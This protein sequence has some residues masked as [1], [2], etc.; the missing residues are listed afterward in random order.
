MLKPDL[1]IE[2]LQDLDLQYEWYSSKVGEDVAERYL[3]AFDQ[4]KLTLCRQPDLGRI[5]H[6]RDR[7]LAKLRSKVVEGS[8]NQHLV[9]YRV[10]GDNLVIFRVLHGMRDLPRRLLEPPGAD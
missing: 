7:R 8:F 5:L 3:F 10:E 1:S 9:F 2:A 6:F 4:T